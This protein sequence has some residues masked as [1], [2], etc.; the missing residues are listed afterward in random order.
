MSATRKAKERI[1]YRA[2]APG[3]YYVEAKLVQPGDGA[4]RLA[5]AKR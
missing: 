3:W 4:Y 2:K 1:A 5:F